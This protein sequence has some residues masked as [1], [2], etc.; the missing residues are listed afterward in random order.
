MEK[1][2]EEPLEGSGSTFEAKA[3]VK[4]DVYK[5]YVFQASSFFHF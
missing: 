2:E 4:S 1:I 3:E 5:A